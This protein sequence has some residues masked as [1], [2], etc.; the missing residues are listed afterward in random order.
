MK[1]IWS[2]SVM[3]ILLAMGQCPCLSDA[4]QD[5]VRVW[6]DQVEPNW[7]P[8]SQRFWYR[9]DLPDRN[10]EFW[11]VDVK[12]Q[13]KKLAFEQDQLSIAWKN[14]DAAAKGGLQRP[15]KIEKLSFRDDHESIGLHCERGG[16]YVW[17]EK[18]GELLIE[19]TPNQ[20]AANSRLFMPPRPSSNGGETCDITMVNRLNRPVEVLW[21]DGSGNYSTRGTTQP[22][23][24]FVQG[25]YDGHVWLIRFSETEEVG[26]FV[27]VK[28]QLEFELAPELV[29]NV[30]RRQGTEQNRR[31]RNRNQNRGRGTQAR[32]SVS[33]DG[34]RAAFVRE[35][36]LWIEALKA[37]VDATKQRQWTQDGNSENSFRRDASRARLVSMQY[38]LPDFPEDT[39]HVFWSP[40]SKFLLAWQ[41]SRV[42]E[43]RVVYV[44]SLPGDQL[45][46]KTQSYPYAKPGDP[47]PIPTPR[48]FAVE[49]G[50]E[51]ALKNDM[52]PNP[53]ELRFE[54]WSEDGRYLFLFYNQR[55]HDCL[56]LLKV[57]LE[58]GDVSAAIDE[59]CPTFIHYSG[60]FVLR[61]LDNSTVLWASERSGWNHLYRYDVET[62][63]VKNAVTQGAWN[64]RRVE[65]MD[66]EGVWFYA[67]GVLPE[68]DP[69]HEHFCYASLDGATFR[70]LTSGDGTHGVQWAPDHKTFLATYSRVDLPPVTELRSA[71]T[72]ELLLEIER[73]EVS[74]IS[75]EIESPGP[76]LPTRFVAKGRD[77]KTDIWGIVHWPSNFDPTK[78]YAVVENI[79]AGPHSHHVPKRFS[80]RYPTQRRIA[81]AGFI[82]VQIDGMGTAWRSKEFHDVCHRNLRDAGFPDRVAWIKALAEKYPQVDAT[83]V[84]IYGGSAGGQNAMA[85]LLWHHDFYSVAVADCGCHD[86]RMD[87][88]WWNEQWMGELGDESHYIA[89]SN[90]E[91]ANLLQG[92]LMLTV[93][94]A[95]RNVDPASTTQVVGK[96]IAANK[97]FTFLPIIGGGHGSGEGSYAAEKR[98][99]FFKRHLG[100]PQ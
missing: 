100:P 22:D 93:G 68:Q 84:G 56:R 7:A 12:Q 90:A 61:W 39:P 67:V 20:A 94:E 24:K 4:A 48:L 31:Q 14:I 1:P 73:A 79:Y 33:P 17:N 21:V 46:P 95:D 78:K 32:Q 83:R 86:N 47:I 89:S 9:V 80:L 69:Y 27:C 71:E 62:G 70:V 38:D 28:G 76:K 96:L 26:C 74:G 53:F 10:R 60:K 34:S 92:H 19:Q 51:I 15:P 40:D 77:G 55:G 87:K 16:L 64:V 49:D 99:E 37:N 41:T 52:F 98:L 63:E 18:T 82:V 97:T 3:V 11:V 54:R 35:D 42:P 88:I 25:S 43:R 23:A 8:D 81:D 85:A 30:E 45:Q 44:E 65:R 2:L 36:N 5:R 50:R 66:Q 57:D 91:N 59:Q 72:G 6:R 29:E 75:S 58:T 13:Q